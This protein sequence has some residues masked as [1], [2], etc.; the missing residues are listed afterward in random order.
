MA[1]IYINKDNYEAEVLNS[2]K[3]VLLDFYADWCGPCRMIAPSLEQI[4]AEHPQITVGK[5][6]VDNNMELA[7]QFNVTSIPLL[8]VMKDGQVINQSLGACPKE[9]ILALLP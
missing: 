4:A 1:L 5:I 2:N 9:E 6:N 8:V 3:V 7:M